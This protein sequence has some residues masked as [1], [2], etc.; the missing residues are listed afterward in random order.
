[1]FSIFVVMLMLFCHVVADYN[2]QG[3]LAQA[4]QKEYWE[5]N[6]PD[7]LYAKD[8][9]CALLMHSISWAFMIMLPIALYLDFNVNMTFVL[10]FVIN[11]LLHMWCDDLKANKKRINL[12]HDQILHIGQI[13][14]TAM[15]FLG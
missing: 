11:T 6:A 2:L 1:M 3:W 4:K 13:A 7:K 8:Y 5:T 12:W 14:Y 15:I 9:I 10:V